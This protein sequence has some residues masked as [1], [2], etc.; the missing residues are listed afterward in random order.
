LPGFHVNL[1]RHFDHGLR[2]GASE[3]ERI[4]QQVLK[5]LLD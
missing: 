4:G 3:L 1:M 2:A 5:D